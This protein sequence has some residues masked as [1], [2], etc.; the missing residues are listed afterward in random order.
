MLNHRSLYIEGFKVL[1]IPAYLL[2]PCFTPA[3]PDM[4]QRHHRCAFP[5]GRGHVCRPRSVHCK[6]ASRDDFHL[7]GHYYSY[8]NHFW[9]QVSLLDTSYYRW[10]FCFCQL[11]V[12]LYIW[13]I[14][15]RL[16]LFQASAFAFLI[17]AQAILRLERWKCPPEGIMH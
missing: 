5:T 12:C 6:P 8:T 7:C 15:P 1:T 10:C 14:L 9:C 11:I 17:P 16:P 4:F 3:L 2:C 13:Y